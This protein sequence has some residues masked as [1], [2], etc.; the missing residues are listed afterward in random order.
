MYPK[1]PTFTVFIQSVIYSFCY[2]SS[3]ISDESLST[4]QTTNLY[5]NAAAGK[6]YIPQEYLQ[7]PQCK[8]NDIIISLGY[9]CKTLISI[10]CHYLYM[11]ADKLRGISIT[12]SNKD[13]HRVDVDIA[14]E[15]KHQKRKPFTYLYPISK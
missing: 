11:F 14:S 15:R 12:F 5:E 8:G 1:I 10:S 9:T 4:P 7:M 3:T 6:D 2:P 13:F